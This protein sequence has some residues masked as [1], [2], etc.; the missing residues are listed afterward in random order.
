MLKVTLDLDL[1]KNQLEDYNMKNLKHYN[2]LSELFRYPSENFLE[3]LLECQSLVDTN[4][5]EAAL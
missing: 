4:Y 5:P 2:L 1:K 3:K